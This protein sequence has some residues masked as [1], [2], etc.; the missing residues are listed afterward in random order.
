MRLKNSFLIFSLATSLLSFTDRVQAAQL[1]TSGS[2]ASGGEI[3]V[4]ADKLSTGNG[5]NQIDATGNVEIKRGET[6]LKADEVRINRATQDVE[7]K[8]K[9]SVNDPEWKVK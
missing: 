5:S 3:N 2:Q 1:T 7:A 9:V 4:T 8:G 6:T